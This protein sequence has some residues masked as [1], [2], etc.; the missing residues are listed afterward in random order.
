MLRKLLSVG[1]V[2]NLISLA[3]W[4]ATVKAEPKVQSGQPVALFNGKDLTSWQIKNLKANNKWVVGRATLDPSNPMKLSVAP[5]AGAGELIHGGGPHLFT[6]KQFGDGILELEFMVAQGAASGVYVLGEYR[7]M[8]R[9]TFGKDKPSIK[10]SGAVSGMISPRVNAARKAG[11]WQ[12]LV[13]EYQAARFEGG[14]KI[15]NFKLIK[16]TMNDQVI[17][18]NVEVTGPTE[19]GLTRKDVSVGPLLFDGN[20]GP[21][22]YRK[23]VFTP[24]AVK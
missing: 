8:I 24:T 18:E 10:D 12:K 15:S 5:A 20:H 14:K 22:A 4:S 13:I 17:H 16:V 11:E 9:D 19:A 23:I 2:L 3:V 1:F 21:A 6:E 7:I